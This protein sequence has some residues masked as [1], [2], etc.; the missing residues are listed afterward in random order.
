[1]QFPLTDLPLE[2]QAEIIRHCD[3]QTYLQLSLV[4]RHIRTLC[5]IGNVRDTQCRVY[6]AN[7]SFNYL[8]LYWITKDGDVIARLCC[9]GEGLIRRITKWNKGRITRLR[10]TDMMTTVVVEGQ[11][12]DY[13]HHLDYDEYYGGTIERIFRWIPYN[14]NKSTIDMCYIIRANGTCA[15]CKLWTAQGP[16]TYITSQLQRMPRPALL[17]HLQSI[18]HHDLTAKY[19]A[20]SISSDEGRKLFPLDIPP[21]E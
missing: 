17:L 12:I 20:V 15:Q 11:T 14:I 19:R 3:Y 16:V 4:S 18:S 13:E 10:R 8:N 2:L 21:S 1:M 9:D 5:Q 6:T 7:D